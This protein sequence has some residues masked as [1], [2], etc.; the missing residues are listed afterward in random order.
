[1]I[2]ATTIS[3]T[4][5]G[6][7][8]SRFRHL[9]IN[10]P[11]CGCHFI[12]QSPC[13]NDDISLTRGRS[14]D[15]AESVHVVPWSSDVHHFHSTTRQA[16]GERPNGAL[17]SPVH[18]IVQSR[19]SILPP[20][21]CVLKGRVRFRLLRCGHTCHRCILG[22][23]SISQA[24]KSFAKLAICHEGTQQLSSLQNTHCHFTLSRLTMITNAKNFGS[25]RP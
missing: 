23:L 20:T 14:E 10:L 12:S 21:V 13:H 5:H 2:V 1:M 9:V 15:D 17:S 25:L 18:K 22:I 6:N 24:G 4:S 11:Q 3:T 19:H 7:D 16:E 8:P